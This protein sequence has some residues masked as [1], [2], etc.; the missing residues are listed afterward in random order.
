MIYEVVEDISR[1]VANLGPSF[2]NY[3]RIDRVENINDYLAMQDA[4]STKPELKE[5][6]ASFIIFQR[7]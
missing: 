3:V 4:L 2:R 1:R 7:L 5:K 6:Y